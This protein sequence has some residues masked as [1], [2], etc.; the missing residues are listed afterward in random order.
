M[1]AVVT[2]GLASA[3]NVYAISVTLDGIVFFASG[4]SVYAVGGAYGSTPIL[5]F[6]PPNGVYRQ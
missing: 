5:L 3:Y 6:S 2:A 1:N 4:A